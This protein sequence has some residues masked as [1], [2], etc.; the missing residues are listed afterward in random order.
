MARDDVEFKT[1]DQVI[2]RGWFYKAHGEK[3]GDR[4]HPCLVMCHGFSA[5]KEMGIDKFAQRF[6]SVLNLSCFVFD[7]R[8]FGDSDTQAGQR[9]HDGIPDDAKAG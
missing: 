3:G 2:L 9:V 8:G 5:I 1:T 4:F 7:H 6:V